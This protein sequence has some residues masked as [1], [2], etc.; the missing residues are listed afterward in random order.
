MRFDRRTSLILAAV[1]ALTGCYT[2]APVDLGAARPGM[3]V[4][5]AL[6]PRGSED[7]AR[8]VGPG[9]ARIEGALVR[10]AA[11]SVELAL[12]RSARRDGADDLWQRQRVAVASGFIA[13][14]RVRR[15]SRT[16][17]WLLAGGAVLGVALS[18][19]FAASHSLGFGLGGEAHT[20]N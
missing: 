8:V 7:L 2:F 19:G 4:E 10:V 15:L 12:V 18:A 13:Q 17:T 11:D 5:V 6:S 3:R 1:P 16:R 9:V 14:A 20:T